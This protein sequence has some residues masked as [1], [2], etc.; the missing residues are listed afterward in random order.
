[1][2]PDIAIEEI[3]SEL[4]NDEYSDNNRIPKI[5]KTI[6]DIMETRSPEIHL[7]ESE[8]LVPE[9]FLDDSKNKQDEIEREKS[10]L[11]YIFHPTHRFILSFF[12]FFSGTQVYDS[13][14]IESM[15]EDISKSKY[16]ERIMPNDSIEPDKESHQYICIFE[17][18]YPAS[19]K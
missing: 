11:Y 6:G 17:H 8:K 4:W 14:V 3:V 19:L 1:M 18:I 10:I 2:S 13:K 7:F 5:G 15:E 12:E 16:K 9:I